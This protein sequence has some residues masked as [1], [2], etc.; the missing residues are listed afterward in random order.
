MASPARDVTRKKQQKK[1]L[2]ITEVIAAAADLVISRPLLMLAP[3]LLDIYYLLG[4]RFTS[5]ATFEGLESELATRDVS[6]SSWLAEHLDKASGLDLMGLLAFIVPSL[7]PDSSDKMHHPV[8]HA[9]IRLDNWGA[10][11]FV[12]VV[13]VGM[14]M[15]LFGFVGLWLADSGLKRNRSWAD[16]ARL[17]TVV[18][19]RF[20][21]L[22]LLFLAMFLLLISPFLIAAVVTSSAE[23]GLESLAVSVGALVFLAMYVLF[24]FAP[25]ALLVDLSGPVD[26]LRASSS[27]VRRNLATTIAFVLVSVFISVGLA[28]V[29]D[30]IATDM[31]GLAIAVIANAFVGTV[32]WIASLLFFS[33]RS[34]LLATDRA[35]NAVTSAIT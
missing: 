31:P 7:M 1:P 30:R 21:L 34:K 4:W 22:A 28:D 26:A 18:G 6:G 23:I 20:F 32:L 15:F 29:W 25:D 9:A 13:V 33:E 24:Y 2:S 19:G 12:S 8:D 3:I 5:G 10:V 35:A 17:G 16:R 11:L 14:G 27:V